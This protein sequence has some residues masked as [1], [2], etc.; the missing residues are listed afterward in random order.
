M[1]FIE[2]RVISL[3]ERAEVYKAL[4]HPTRL[5]IFEKILLKIDKALKDQDSIC[6]SDIA[7]MFDF[8]LPTISKHL[9][10]LKHAGLIKTH[11]DGKKIIITINIQKTKKICESLSSLITKHQ[12]N[13][14]E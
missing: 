12:E 8:T 9:E 2:R 10:I 5:E 6:V 1:E 3:K 13:L 7:S 4:G 14:E 11:K